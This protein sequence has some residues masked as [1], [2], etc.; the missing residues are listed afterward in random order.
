MCRRV[1]HLIDRELD[2]KLWIFQNYLLY[3]GEALDRFTG[4]DGKYSDPERAKLFG[5][6]VYNDFRQL[7]SAILEEASKFFNKRIFHS[8]FTPASIS[9]K[10]YKLPENFSKLAL[11]SKTEEI[12][13]LLNS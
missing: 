8:Q 11:F 10:D 1:T 2:H 6:I 12:N 5:T 3:L 13:R 4:T 9:T 7:T